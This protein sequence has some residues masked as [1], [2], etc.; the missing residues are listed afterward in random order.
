MDEVRNRVATL[1]GLVGPRGLAARDAVI[2]LAQA[3]WDITFAL[4][5][6]IENVRPQIQQEIERVQNPPQENP[7]GAASST[8]SQKVKPLKE[9]LGKE[10]NLLDDG[11]DEQ[12]VPAGIQVIEIDH[13][14]L[15]DCKGT[16][17]T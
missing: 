17:P 4:R 10:K 7:K 9:P 15:P 11:D 16:H 8:F 14:D 3:R 2:L 5:Q 13:P 6:Y 12:P 1:L